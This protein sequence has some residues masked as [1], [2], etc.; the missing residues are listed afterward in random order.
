M[1]FKIHQDYYANPNTVYPSHLFSEQSFPNHY[2]AAEVEQFLTRRYG[3]IIEQA[4][5]REGGRLYAMAQKQGPATIHTYA[6]EVTP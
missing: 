1:K 5:T 2:T 3:P 6:R 4:T